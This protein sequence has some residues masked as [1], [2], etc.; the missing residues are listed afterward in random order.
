MLQGGSRI[1]LAATR[2]VK[3]SKA[4]G[5]RRKK[6]VEWLYTVCWV[7]VLLHLLEPW[8]PASRWV[9]SRCTAMPRFQTLTGHTALHEAYLRPSSESLYSITRQ[10]ICTVLEHG[11]PTCCFSKATTPASATPLPQLHKGGPHHDLRKKT[12]SRSS[13]SPVLHQQTRD[14]ETGAERHV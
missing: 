13:R 7:T 5:I 2:Q 8:G 6:V 1:P 9:K 12:H 3:V 10:G 11:R 4:M 14:S